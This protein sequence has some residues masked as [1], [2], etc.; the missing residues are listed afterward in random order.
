M[1]FLKRRSN[2]I[3]YIKNIIFNETKDF[4]KTKAKQLFDKI[5]CISVIH[6][7]FFKCYKRDY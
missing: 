1:L 6:L 5:L 2:Y 4:L 7:N 3:I